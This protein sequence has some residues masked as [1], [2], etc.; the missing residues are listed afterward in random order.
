M[1]QDC[2]QY[3]M[4]KQ[5]Q[6][7]KKIKCKNCQTENEYVDLSH[8]M[9]GAAGVTG[10]NSTARPYL[11]TSIWRHS[12]SRLPWLV[13]LV[14][15]ALFAGL[16]VSHYES[17]FLAMPILVAFIPMLMGIAGA[18]GSQSSTVIIRSLAIGE[19]STK[20]YLR[21]FIK[22]LWIS[23]ICGALV[24]LVG[25]GYILVV[26]RHW[27][28]GVVLYLGLLATIIFAKLLGMLLPIGA[29]KIK[30]DPALISSPL[31]TIIAD[32]FGIF[33]YFTFAQMM[34]NI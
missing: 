10:K 8:D 22:E 6:R 21:A 4:A 29:K 18:G 26:E 12:W 1:T 28:L 19:I 17:S 11:Q 3:D 7:T 5:S 2:T 24:G 9:C 27:R 32:I 23:L 20:Q 33:A 16:L 31:V 30:I 34:L 14:F 15:A 13:F 25:L